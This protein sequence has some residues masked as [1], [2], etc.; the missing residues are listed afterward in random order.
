MLMSHL[1]ADTIDELIEMVQLI[2]I[3]KKWIQK[4]GTE[5]EHFDICDSK[6]LLAL[7]YGAKPITNHEL[8]NIIRQK[9]KNNKKDKQ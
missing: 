4:A 9:R 2:G 5:Q 3:D 6:R 1:L 7:R 8:V